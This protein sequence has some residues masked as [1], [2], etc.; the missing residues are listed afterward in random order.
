VLE[1]ALPSDGVQLFVEHA[2][3]IDLLMTDLVMPEMPGSEL[4]DRLVSERPGLR[5]LFVSGYTDA[6]TTAASHAPDAL[7]LSKPFVPSRLLDTVAEALSTP[8]A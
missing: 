3:E 8:T 4:A 6:L 5:V 7:V 1:A 2:D